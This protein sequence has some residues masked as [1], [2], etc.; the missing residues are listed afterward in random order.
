MVTRLRLMLARLRALV[1]DRR[2]DDD[3]TAELESHIELLADQHLRR[4]LAPAEARRLAAVTVG[5]VNALRQRHRDARGLPLLDDLWQDLRFASRLIVKDRWFSAA[6][7]AAIALGIGANTLGFTIINAAFIRGFSFDQAQELHAVSWRHE[8]GRRV[9]LSFADYQDWRSATRTFSDLAA[10]DFGAVNISDDV[11]APEQTQGAW[12]TANHFTVLRQSPLV[13]RGFTA[14]DDQRGAEPVVIIGHDIW[15]L[16][17][18]QDPAVLGRMLRVNGRP[19]TIVGVMPEGMK[20][21]DN[22]ELWMPFVPTDAQ[23]ARSARRLGV[24]GRLSGGVTKTSALAEIDGIARRVMAAHVDDTRALAG[25]RVETLVERFMGGAARPMFITVMG[26]V[27]FVLLIACANVANLLLSRAMYRTREVAVRYSLGATR[28]RVVRQLLIESLAL[29]AI[30]GVLGLV[31]ATISVGAFDAAIQLSQPPYWLRFTIDYRVLTYV[32]GVCIATAVLFG[33]APALHVSRDQHDTLKDGARG[34]TGRG[35]RRLGNSLVVAELALTVVLL[36]GA[37][38]MLRSF[39]ALGNTDPGFT[40]DGLMRMRMQLPPS[41]Y[42]TADGRLRFY[43]QLQ[44][45]LAAI[46]GV[47]AAAITTSVPPLDDEQWRFEIDGQPIP[48]EERRP[49]VATV[50]ITPD[51]FTVLGVALTRGRAFNEMDGAPGSEHVI[52][53]QVMADRY[54]GDQDPIGQRLRFTARREQGEPPQPWRTI[55]GVIAAL[56]QGSA[57]EAFRS[58]V[59]YVPFRQSPPRTAS[60]LIRSA[61]PPAEV[62][63]AVRATVQSLDADQPVFTVQTLAQAF[64]EERLIYRVFATLF[65]VLGA[66][67]L[68]LSAVGIY[69]VMA[70]AVTQRTHEI[71]VRMAIGAARWQVSWLFLKRALAQLAAGLVLGVPAA[72]ALARLARFRLVEVE[73]DDPVT[74]IAI[75]LVLASV[76]MAACLL[77]VRKAARV[78]P[79]TALRSE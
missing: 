54:F 27:I 31:L 58:A 72:L 63:A 24:F 16:R 17:F 68:V 41:N 69:G 36:C 23:L 74:L 52:I 46:P 3:F 9:P 28:W 64:D 35:S 20:F 34:S 33:L 66:I 10:Y 37:G 53:S 51:Y 38:L 8:Q 25:A 48:E 43:T 40:V 19:A 22:S 21:P 49:F 14:G 73:A 39:A 71:G 7:V 13:G 78:D 5:N 70:Y 12:V 65:A 44:P 15:R 1:T 6:A 42:P 76:S 45:R 75:T 55:V 32:A 47:Q 29:S 60:L 57:D 79:A 67:A 62:M 50:T 77:P 11:A 4:G 56:R 26:A 61:L 30:G 18:Q 2:H 59:V